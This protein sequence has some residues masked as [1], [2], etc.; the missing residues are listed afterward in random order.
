MQ[1]FSDTAEYH[2]GYTES[3]SQT[4]VQSMQP[5]YSSMI[6]ATQSTVVPAPVPRGIVSRNIRSFL[7]HFMQTKTAPYQSE[8]VLR[9]ASTNTRTSGISVTTG[10]NTESNSMTSIGTNTEAA[11]LIAASTN[12]DKVAIRTIATNTELPDVPKKEMRTV[13]TSTELSDVMLTS[14]MRMLAAINAGL[15]DVMPTREAMDRS[16][17]KQ[18]VLKSILL[19]SLAFSLL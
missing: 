16:E 10:T 18:V 1:T 19:I 11:E 12:T 4:S 17:V 14:Q 8:K 13:A 15:S 3:N 2:K 6:A 5:H 9:D 7:P